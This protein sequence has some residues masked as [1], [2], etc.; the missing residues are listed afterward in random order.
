MWFLFISGL[1]SVQTK[2]Y[3]N[4]P[5]FYSGHRVSTVK[6]VFFKAKGNNTGYLGLSSTKLPTF[7][8]KL[9]Y[10]IVLGVWA[11]V[12]T[13]GQQSSTL[14]VKN[15]SAPFNP[16]SGSQKSYVPFDKIESYWLSWTSSQ[17]RLGHGSLVGERTIFTADISGT[18]YAINHI[19][20]HSSW[21]N[22]LDWWFHDGKVNNSILWIGQSSQGHCPKFRYIP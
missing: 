20:F 18:G 10:E 22:Y 13:T 14:L 12:R 7:R 2:D 21:Y 1:I 8:N 6:E 5:P 3:I 17:M 19:G 9:L 15:E 11:G 16:A 4:N